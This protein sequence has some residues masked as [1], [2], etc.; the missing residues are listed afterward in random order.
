MKVETI[1]KKIRLA[2]IK[3]ILRAQTSLLNFTRFTKPDY[4]VKWFHKE[5]CRVLDK[6]EEGDIQKLMI[7]VPPQHG[8][9]ELSSR[10]FPAYV[11]GRNPDRK[12]ALCSYGVEHAQSFNRDIQRI[13]DNE[14]YN[15]LFPE[16]V[17]NQSNVATTSKGAYKR[18]ANIF[19][20]VGRKGFLKTVGVGSA[21][22]GTT[23]DIGIIDDPFKDREEA[24]SARIREKVWNWYTDVF[25]TRLHNESQQLLLFTRWHEEDLAGKILERDGVIESGGEW[26]VVKF[27]AIKEGDQAPND[28]VTDNRNIGEALWEDRHGAEK[29]LKM[30][31]TSPRTFA[32]LAQQEPAPREG[33]IIKRDY[34]PIVTYEEIPKE[35][36][37]SQRHFVV[38]TAYTANKQNDPNA[39]LCFSVYQN[40]LYIWN[41]DR[42]W[43]EFSELK[44]RL[45][46]NVFEWGDSKS[47]MLIEPKAS[48]L[49]IFQSIRDST[50][51][52]VKRYKMQDGDK[53]TRATSIE[54]ILASERVF[55][56]EGNWNNQFIE[57]CGAFP[58]AKHD[59]AIDTLVMAVRT[60]L[61]KP[62]RKGRR[63]ITR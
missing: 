43:A 15:K 22:T 29:Y 49:S 56:V 26:V 27:P 24:E 30:K 36:F 37:A 20:T 55:L 32:S 52:N 54:D 38:D 1:Q 25:E 42:F 60:G 59:E 39:C 8:K 5:I 63:S 16:T 40:K 23:V 45:I 58:N 10:R 9:S 62:K 14:N 17:L 4:E 61:M 7:F 47:V 57:E 31:R 6:L 44:K 50:R 2:K 51:N 13:I 12:V 21:L 3:K 11:L 18:T 28:Y 41:Y 46:D 48:G 35:A 53:I 33:G 34:L 19:E